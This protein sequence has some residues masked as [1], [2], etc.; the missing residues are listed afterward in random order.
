M[1]GKMM[2]WLFPV[3]AVMCLVYLAHYYVQGKRE[4]TEREVWEE[5]NRRTD[6]TDSITQGRLFL[7]TDA[8][9]AIIWR[10]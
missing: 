8:S 9:G 7:T 1:N 2:E 5:E 4:R 6:L 3:A 10:R